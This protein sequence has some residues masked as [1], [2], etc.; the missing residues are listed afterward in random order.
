MTTLIAIP[1]RGRANLGTS[2]LRWIPKEYRDRTA[3]FVHDS[4]EKKY[5]NS[6]FN[7]MFSQIN[8]VPLNYTF[9]GEKRMLMADWARVQ[10][11]D[12]IVMI[13]DDI[14]GFA[15]RIKSG[16]TGLRQTIDQDRKE[17]F[18]TVDDY[19]KWYAHVG[20][21]QRFHNDAFNGQ[22]PIVVENTRMLRFLGYRI[23]EFLSCDHGR[24]QI[25]E[26]FDITLQLLDK[27][28]KNAVLFKWCQDQSG[29]GTEGGCALYRTLE[30]HNSNI[31]RLHELWPTVT[32][33]REKNTKSSKGDL[34]SRMDLVIDWKNAYKP[35]Q[36]ETIRKA[37]E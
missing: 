3:L 25:G 12:N 15:V 9:I 18:E 30:L 28:L 4:E 26:D 20:V 22:D 13:D 29:T 8:L 34:S 31:Q 6:L 33:I 23:D 2:T 27:G 11:Y 32:R 21:S 17:M 24:V 37:M 19:L 16:E 5:K 14:S 7:Y 36:E 1:S 35:S 10:G